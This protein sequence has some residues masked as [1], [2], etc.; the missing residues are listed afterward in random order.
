MTIQALAAILDKLDEIN[1]TLLAIAIEK[2]SVLVANHVEQ[3]NQL[4]NKENKLIRM[5]ADLDRNRVEAVNQYLLARGY[6]P[7]PRITLG[8]L[9]KLIFLSRKKRSC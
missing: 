8:D 5:A 9:A 7:N 1:R 3:L 6:H 4:V 2:R